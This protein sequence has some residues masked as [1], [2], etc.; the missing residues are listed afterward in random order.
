MDGLKFGSADEFKSHY[1]LIINELN[2]EIN[3]SQE[4]SYEHYRDAYRLNIKA[5]CFFVFLSFFFTLSSV[6]VLLNKDVGRS[7]LTTYQ[8]KVIPIDPVHVE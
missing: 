2:S 3:L 7:F 6:F 1:D 4:S 8:G 5:V